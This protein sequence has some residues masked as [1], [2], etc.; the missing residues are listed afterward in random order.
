MK[1]LLR[2][3]RWGRLLV[4][5]IG[6]VALSWVLVFV[7]VFGYAFKLGF[8]ARG[9]PD[10]GAIEQ[11]AQGTAPVV[12]PIA[13]ILI[14]VLAAAWAA[15]KARSPKVNGLALGVVVA[16]LVVVTARPPAIWAV[17]LALLAVAAGGLGGRLA[18]ARP[19]ERV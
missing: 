6:T 19:P 2:S 13:A 8:E 3:I 7:M 18:G 10:Q 4:G 11:F 5:A 14:T 17:A 1:E 15:R 9:S 12:G 16:A